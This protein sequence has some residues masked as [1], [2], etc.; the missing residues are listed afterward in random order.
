MDA[1]EETQKGSCRR[2]R[3]NAGSAGE[4]EKRDGKRLAL[5]AM[6]MASIVERKE[7]VGCA[8]RSFGRR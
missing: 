2:W 5:S 4:D 3:G 8:G 6:S 7:L 1:I